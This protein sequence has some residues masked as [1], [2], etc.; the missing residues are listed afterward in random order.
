MTSKKRP[1]VVWVGNTPVI[2]WT[3]EE[4]RRIERRIRKR[5]EK[6]RRTYKE[7]PARG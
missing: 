1:K 7:I 4:H 2:P 3:A 6:L 5:Y